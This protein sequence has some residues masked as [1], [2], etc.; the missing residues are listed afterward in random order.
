MLEKNDLVRV[1]VIGVGGC[2]CEAVNLM[3]KDSV[4]NMDYIS[5]DTD[6]YTLQ[7]SKAFTRILLGNGGH[8]EGWHEISRLMT[9]EVSDSI[10]EALNNADMLFVIAGMGGVTGSQAS[11]II[12]NIA[13][14]MGI[15]TVG[16]VTIPFLFEGSRRCKLA[17]AGLAELKKNVDTLVSLSNEKIAANLKEPSVCD[18]FHSVAEHIALA[19]NSI[20]DLLLKEVL[21]SLDFDEVR[22][23][24]LKKGL[25][26]LGVGRAKGKNKLEQAAEM[27]LRNPVLEAPIKSAKTAIL[28]V[29]G[30]SSIE[31]K[32]LSKAE[33]II[34]KALDPD[35]EIIF[36][37]AIDDGMEDEVMISLLAIGLEEKAS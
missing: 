19:I 34:R 27:T 17:E 5:I 13:R 3:I 7:G 15:L 20:T 9:N 26:R 33:R 6:P 10:A 28:S 16:V 29:V 21:I 35:T 4:T 31:L 18:A 8:C 37:T 25:A 14:E 32:E 11:P 24:M 12:A 22:T 30:D 36:G 23:V 1:K 2:G